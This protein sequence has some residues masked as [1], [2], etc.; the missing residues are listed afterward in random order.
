MP[1]IGNFLG[2]PLGAL[3]PIKQKQMILI[4]VRL[5]A[6]VQPSCNPFQGQGRF[7][8]APGYSMRSFRAIWLLATPVSPS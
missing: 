3:V 5:G 8:S 1:S 6:H 4:Q 2:L 7:M